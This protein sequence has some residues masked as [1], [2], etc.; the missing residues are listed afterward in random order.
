MYYWLSSTFQ[1]CV[2]SWTLSDL[3]ELETTALNERLCEVTHIL[4]WCTNRNQYITCQQ[5]DSF[6]ALRPTHGLWNSQ[7]FKK[8]WLR[9][10][11]G[12]RQASE[13][14]SLR[15]RIFFSNSANVLKM[16]VFLQICFFVRHIWIRS[17]LPLEEQC[18]SGRIK[19]LNTISWLHF[20]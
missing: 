19:R 12:R 5:S 8:P 20:Y 13:L 9:C 10:T 3:I 14:A 11:R 4:A 7:T 16:Y 6:L 2:D 18:C 1:W 15:S 17:K